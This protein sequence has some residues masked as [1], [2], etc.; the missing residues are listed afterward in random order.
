MKKIL[1]TV[2][3]ALL[4]TASIFAS[5][6]TEEESTAAFPSK[7]ITCIVIAKAGGGTDTMARANTVPL[8]ET[9]GKPI[10]VINNGTAGGMIAMDDISKA[11]SDGYTIGVFSN[12]D[13][14]NFVYGDTD[15][16]FTLEDFTYIAGL[17]QSGDLLVLKKD[18]QFASTEEFIAYAKANPGKLTVGLPSPI[19][20]MSLGMVE[21]GMDI[22]VTSVVYSGGNKVFADLIGG[23]VEAG[24]LGTKFVTQLKEQDMTILGLLLNERL[25][26]IPEVPTLLEQGYPANNPVKRM[27]VGPKDMPADVVAKYVA[28]LEEGFAEGGK[29]A[30]NIIK[31]GEVPMLVTGDEL[32]AF[33]EEDFAM[34]KEYLSK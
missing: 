18:S 33:L 30:E 7:E 19:Q 13:A 1:L 16:G 29:I 5:G 27:L 22:D 11:D 15:P 12:T 6:Q 28:A 34:R 10:V 20:E 23:H 17:N 21:T 24:I 4:A 25:S 32:A 31:I 26:S 2:T 14:P 9:L 8:E 3:V